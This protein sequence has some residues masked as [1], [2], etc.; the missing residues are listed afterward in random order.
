MTVLLLA[1]T[2]LTLALVVL[3]WPRTADA[4]CDTIDGPAVADGRTALET[5]NVNHA[6]RWVGP[7]AEAEVTEVFGLATRVRTLG[8]D[9]LTVADRLFLETL[10][11]LHRAGEGA[12]F[13]GLKPSGTPVDPVVAAADAAIALGRIDPLVGLVAGERLHE[14]EHR[15]QHALALKDVPVDDVEAGRRSLA[16]YVAFVLYAE[17]EDDHH[18][19]HALA[20][21]GHHHH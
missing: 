7:D 8:G 13:D 4:H 17:G 19:D 9:A 3:L 2:A 15:L 18:G 6:L 14:L 12:P 5:G 20:S 16:A 21:A 1:A 11:R 10:V